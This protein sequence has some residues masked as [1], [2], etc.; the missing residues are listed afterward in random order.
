[1]PKKSDLEKVF[2]FADSTDVG[3]RKV[4][5]CGVRRHFMTVRVGEDVLTVNGEN[6]E[7]LAKKMVGILAATYSEFPGK[8]ARELREG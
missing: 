1:M 6:L 4:G 8:P 7:D 3:A 2:D 5:P